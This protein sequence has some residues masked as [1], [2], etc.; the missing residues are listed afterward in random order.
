[1]SI[2]KACHNK[3]GLIIFGYE[4]E[5]NPIIATTYC[6]CN[7]SIR[8][9]IILILTIIMVYDLQITSTTEMS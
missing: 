1:M 6:V 4:S 8:Y 2:N 3:M 5:M 7:E 9:I